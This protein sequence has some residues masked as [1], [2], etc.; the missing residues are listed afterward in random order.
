METF[1]FLSLR[2]LIV[3]GLLAC[4]KDSL[5]SKKTEK[6]P[7]HWSVTKAVVNGN[8]W[9]D[10]IVSVLIGLDREKS[11]AADYGCKR[12]TISSANICNSHEG[13]DTTIVDL[14]MDISEPMKE[15][16]TYHLDDQNLGGVAGWIENWNHFYATTNQNSTGKLHISK[17][18]NDKISGTFSFVARID[19]LDLTIK[20]EHGRFEDMNILN[21]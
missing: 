16:Q 15:G 18:K 3:L 5:T 17:F 11:K 10:C 4:S 7:F 9:G 1:R 6:P 8:L 20:V 12:F 2:L 19:S 21:F 14:Y 13:V